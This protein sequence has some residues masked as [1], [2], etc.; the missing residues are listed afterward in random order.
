VVNSLSKSHGMTGW[1]LG[2][3]TAPAEVILKLINLNIVS[4]Y[5][6]AD[7]ISHAAVAAVEKRYGVDEIADRYKARRKI[8]MDALE[9]AENI[10]IRGTKGAMY[11]M[12]DVSSIEPEAETFAWALLD[13][14]QIAALP[15]TSFGEAAQGHLRFSM[16]QEEHLLK[17]AAERIRRF[18]KNYVRRAD[19]AE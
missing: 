13:A 9:G 16:C 12:L 5:G 18:A 1:R 2:W 3:L 7:F 19:A 14:E 6:M 8:F 4:S 11:V 10:V 15:G 17:T